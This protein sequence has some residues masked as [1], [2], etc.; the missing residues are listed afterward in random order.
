MERMV[1]IK[2]D[3]GYIKDV[4]VTEDLLEFS[5]NKKDACIMM[6]LSCLHTVEIFNACLNSGVRKFEI[7]NSEYW[8]D[9]E[10]NY[11]IE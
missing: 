8:Y 6:P 2:T 9:K 4:N 3:K 1:L 5:N 10:H 11:M 7:M